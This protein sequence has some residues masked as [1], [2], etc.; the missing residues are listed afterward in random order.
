L[1]AL[2]HPP[3][4][5]PTPRTVLR[6]PANSTPRTLTRTHAAPPRGRERISVCCGS[7]ALASV[8]IIGRTPFGDGI[9]YAT[10]LPPTL[11]SP[12]QRI[13]CDASRY[14]ISCRTAWPH[15]PGTLHILYRHILPFICSLTTMVLSPLLYRGTSS[16]LLYHGFAARAHALR[17]IALRHATPPAVQ[18][19][20]ATNN[21]TTVCS[22]KDVSRIGDT[23]S[24]PY[25]CCI[26]LPTHP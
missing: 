3:H 25:A 2:T 19:A 6:T 4:P 15:A 8:V 10:L 22:T 20:P 12:S 23:F 14:T 26:R 16:S 5:T 11:H 24:P 13:S 1:R 21:G 9:S 17:D 7:A 18:A